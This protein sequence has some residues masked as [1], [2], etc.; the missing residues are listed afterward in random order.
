MAH[1]VPSNAVYVVSAICASE[2][3]RPSSSSQIAC[4]YLMSSQAASSMLSQAT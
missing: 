2:I 3:Q 1:R 4:G